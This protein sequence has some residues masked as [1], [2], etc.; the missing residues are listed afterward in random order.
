M[1]AL[2]VASDLALP[3]EIVTQT[4]GVLAKRRAGK[5]YLLARLVEELW[6]AQQQVVILDPKGDWWGLRSSADGK[7]EGIPILILGGE[8]KDV[9][10][11]PGAGD[12]VARMVVEER[13]SAL[14][15]L[16]ELRKHEVAT[17]CAAFLEQLYRLKAREEFRTAMM[18]VVDEADAIA[19]Q[20]PQRGEERMLGAA[21]DIVRRGGQRGIG[22]A[23]ATQRAA[24]LNKN[25]LT[26]VQILV[27]LRLIAPQDL[28]AMNAW[29]D[30][31]GTQEQRRALMASLPALPTGTAWFWSPGWPTTQG[32]F[33]R[34][35]VSR[36][37]TFDSG[38][39]PR[40]GETRA[41]PKTV[42]DVDL[43]AVQKRMAATLERAKAED[44]RELRKRIAALEGELRQAK[45]AAPAPK[46]ERV[47]ISVLR[48]GQVRALDGLVARL[49]KAVTGVQAAAAVVDAQ[50]REIRAAIAAARDPQRGAAGRTLAAAGRSRAAVPHLPSRTVAA[51]APATQQR[52]E[53]VT[54]AQ[55]RILDALAWLEGVGLRRADRTQ[56]AL[57]A[58]ASPTSS[59]YA[60]NLGS[61]RSGGLVDYPG[62][63]AVSLT[64]HGATMAQ[65]TE[66][67]GTS[68]E[69]QAAFLRR[70]SPAKARILSTLIAEYPRAVGRDQLA[71][72]SGAS[73]SSSAYANN[74]GSLRSLGVIDYRDGGVVALPVLFLEGTA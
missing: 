5:S 34:A 35:E 73:F 59:A 54:P 21:E 42:A 60:N 51:R 57:L 64:E 18:L 7:G 4:I 44:P 63:N 6:K 46:V 33:A 69:L 23:M 62:P 10:L 49:E 29:V 55:Q 61:L 26:Q 40:P 16:S 65:A 27:A 11:E 56:L 47:E 43:A 48:D 28:E 17:F 74:L 52:A 66:V 71:E 9:K 12:V 36:R 20:R 25:V 32:I 1:K 2:R 38:A 30:V 67:P 13:V 3:L 31:H 53:G 68:A 19:P 58:G 15:D 70:L 45:A 14:L 72:R 24:V 22:C 41:A 37:W 8:H 39:T 50:A